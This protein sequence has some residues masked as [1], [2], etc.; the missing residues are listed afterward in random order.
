VRIMAAIFTDK[1]AW[2]QALF[3]VGRPDMA[4]Y[5]GPESTC[6]IGFSRDRVLVWRE[7]ESR[8]NSLLAKEEGCILCVSV[9]I[10]NAL[11]ART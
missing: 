11:L 2:E 8:I 7:I 6:K 10:E 9:A 1:P 4:F 5:T 3:K